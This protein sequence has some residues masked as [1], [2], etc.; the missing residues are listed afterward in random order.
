MNIDLLLLGALIGAFVIN[1]LATIR[2]W[3]IERDMADIVRDIA[4][5]IRDVHGMLRVWAE[6]WP[7][8]AVRD[9]LL[10]QLTSRSRPTPRRSTDPPTSNYLERRA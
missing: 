2:K 7:D 6:T 3:R 1:L 4:P 9:R 8:P 5:V 10:R